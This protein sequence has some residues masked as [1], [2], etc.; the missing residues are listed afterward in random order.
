[1]KRRPTS[2]HLQIYRPQLTSGT[3]IL[4]R[5]TGIVLA[6]GLPVL[7]A[8][9]I[10]LSQSRES[11]ALAQAYAGSILGRVALFVWSLAFFYHLLNGIR[12]LMWDAGL[13]LDIKTAYRSGYAAIGGTFLLTLL[14]WGLVY[15]IR[16]QHG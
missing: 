5:I 10:A 6:L 15:F 11:F 13:G 1:M 14:V 3:S 7:I 12:H 8:W 2:P 16:G 4:H 9:F